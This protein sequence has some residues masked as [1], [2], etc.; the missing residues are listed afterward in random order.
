MNFRN[1]EGREVKVKTELRFIDIDKSVSNL[2]HEKLKETEI[3]KD[4]MEFTSRKGVYIRL[5]EQHREVQ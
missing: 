1:K 4:K 2:S 3:F 5:H